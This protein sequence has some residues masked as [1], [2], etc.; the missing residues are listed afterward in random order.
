VVALAG[1]QKKTQAI[2][3]A[4]KSEVIDVLVTDRFTAARLIGEEADL[5][6]WDGDR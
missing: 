2:A 5:R 4:L 6:D 1:G 3:A